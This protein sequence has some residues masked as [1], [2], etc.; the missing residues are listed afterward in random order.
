MSSH[1]YKIWDQG[2]REGRV[3]TKFYWREFLYALQKELNERQGNL[4]CKGQG[5]SQE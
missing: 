2:I 1:C 5:T 3:Y 4:K